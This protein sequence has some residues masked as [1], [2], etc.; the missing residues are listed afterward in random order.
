[1]TVI[2][3]TLNN[4]LAFFE[5]F[6]E[7]KGFKTY[8]DSFHSI[9]Y[10]DSVDIADINEQE[11]TI[12][13][14]Y[15]FYEDE[16]DGPRE[17]NYLPK[18]EKHVI[19]KRDFKKELHL[20]LTQ[21]FKKAKKSIGNFITESVDRDTIK[22]YL[23]KVLY[24]TKYIAKHLDKNQK[25]KAY[26][27]NLD[28]LESLVRYIFIK[29]E[30]FVSELS[31]DEFF[32]K[33][34]QSSQSTP[35]S[36]IAAKSSSKQN[37]YSSFKWIGNSEQLQKLHQSMISKGFIDPYVELEYFQSVFDQ[38]MLNKPLEIK[39]L[40]LGKNKLTS[41]PSLFYFYDQL[42]RAE[43]IQEIESNGTLYKMLENIFVDHNGNKLEN[44]KVSKSN[45]KQMKIVTPQEIQINDI[46][47]ELTE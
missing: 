36:Q 26:K 39:W 6:F 37:I 18:K 9:S 14:E 20:K 42:V 35:L 34:I 8:Y 29:Y 44:L 3:T 2:K 38:S 24:Q 45:S 21:E 17:G 28:A 5:H 16:F 4:P 7:K 12:T 32:G 11:E 27:S 19:Y 40:V 46:L 31:N 13:Y 23:D 22:T 30:P 1:M 43:L 15:W 25:A 47:S 10:K 41:K 33:I